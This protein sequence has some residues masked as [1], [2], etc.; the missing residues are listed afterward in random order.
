MVSGP[1]YAS[2]N[3]STRSVAFVSSV[4]AYIYDTDIGCSKSAVLCA[5]MQKPSQGIN[6]ALAQMSKGVRI[7]KFVRN[8][9]GVDG[10]Q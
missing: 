10:I 1:N 6:D 9:G 8:T 3:D 5:K 2:E 4:H 7:V